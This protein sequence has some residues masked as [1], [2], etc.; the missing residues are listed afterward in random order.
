[1][2]NKSKTHKGSAKRFRLKASGLIK[3]KKAGF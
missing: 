2:A 1:M 3:R